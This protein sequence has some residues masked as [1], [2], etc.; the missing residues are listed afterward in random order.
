M[1]KKIP[2]VCQHCGPLT[3]EEAQTHTTRYV[4]GDWDGFPPAIRQRTD[5]NATYLVNLAHPDSTSLYKIRG[6][7]PQRAKELA[8]LAGEVPQ[9]LWILLLGALA[10]AAMVLRCSWH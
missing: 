1:A 3:D 5:P 9:I 7:D 6:Y 2:F 8:A 10:C 4:Q